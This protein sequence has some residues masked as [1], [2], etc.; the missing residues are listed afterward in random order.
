MEIVFPFFVAGDDLAGTIGIMVAA[1][2]G[3]RN[4]RFEVNDAKRT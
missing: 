4:I 2:G 3:T 1:D